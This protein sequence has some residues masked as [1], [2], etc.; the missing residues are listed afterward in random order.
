SYIRKLIQG[1]IDIIEAE[2]ER[3]ET[4]TERTLVE[5]LAQILADGPRPPA[6]GLGRHVAAE[7]SRVAEHR[8]YAER[9]VADVQLSALGDN[10]DERLREVR[11][12][13]ATEEANVSAQRHRV[14]QI[15]DACS[16]ELTR[17][18]RDGEAEVADLLARDAPAS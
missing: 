4:G 3:R 13:L 10:S 16:A 17:R 1:R 12:E 5:D 11:A 7:P 15:A 2:L 9:L 8:R 14:Q 18:Y 6:F